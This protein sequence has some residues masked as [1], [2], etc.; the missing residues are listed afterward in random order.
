MEQS[1]V[2]RHSQSKQQL[3]RTRQHMIR[4]SYY[5]FHYIL[6]FS[7]KRGGE[8]VKNSFNRAIWSHGDFSKQIPGTVKG[9]KNN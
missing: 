5:T 7:K 3:V 8:R 6:Y 4:C 1:M 9:Q 2:P